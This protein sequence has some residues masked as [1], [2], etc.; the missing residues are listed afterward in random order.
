MSENIDADPNHHPA[1][2][3]SVG[4]KKPPVHTRFKPGQSGN[5]RGRPKRRPTERERLRKILEAKVTVT[6]DGKK[7]RLPLSEVILKQLA[8][9]AVSGDLPSMRLLL[10]AMEQFNIGTKSDDGVFTFI[11]EDR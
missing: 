10:Q 2:H 8:K 9:K 4:Y 5:P 6:E 3:Y 1:G 7:K 11:V